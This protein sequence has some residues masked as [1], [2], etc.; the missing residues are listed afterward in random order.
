MTSANPGKPAAR[1]TVPGFRDGRRRRRECTGHNGVGVIFAGPSAA[2]A[3]PGRR[4][5]RRDTAA[6]VSRISAAPSHDAPSLRT[7]VCVTPHK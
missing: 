7:V 3:I 4:S 5:H 1:V 6:I 2:S